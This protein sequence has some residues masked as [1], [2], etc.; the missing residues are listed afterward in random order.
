MG[1]RGYT[2]S[3]ALV[4]GKRYQ[5]MARAGGHASSDL[6]KMGV[7]SFRVPLGDGKPSVFA[8]CYY[9]LMLK[10]RKGDRGAVHCRWR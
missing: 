3:V 4:A 1:V 9:Q 5:L 6:A 2:I 10:S 7:L 8:S